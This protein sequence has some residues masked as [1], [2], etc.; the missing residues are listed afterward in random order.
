M[1]AGYVGTA[2]AAYL[3]SSHHEVYISTAT[4]EKLAGLKQHA[5]HVLLINNRG[6]RENLRLIIETC[7][8]MVIL[9]APKKGKSYE[10][11]Y[12]ETA[13][14]VSA[15][16][17]ERKKPFYLLYTSSTSVYQ[18]QQDW[19]TEETSLSPKSVN[20]SILL[21][22]EKLLLTHPESCILRLGGIYGPQRELQRRAKH[23]SGEVMAT[24]GKEPTN[25]IH[26]EDIVS[27]ISFCLNHR[28][29][30]VYNLVNDDHPSRKELYSVLCHSINAPEP[31]WNEEFSSEKN[32]GYKVSNAKIYQ[33][34]FKF[35]HSTL[36]IE[37][38]IQ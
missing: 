6:D 26:L 21:Q 8:G 5:K 24:S 37:N 13:K 9:V 11:T 30:G 25:H 31:I 3:Q 27:A 4:E 29:I 17:K 16:L 33:A 14:I 32:D 20:S 28:L 2:L 36:K 18:G 10:E 7:D 12:L 19:V 15:I 38:E 1:G 23:V 34:G 35:K 22:T